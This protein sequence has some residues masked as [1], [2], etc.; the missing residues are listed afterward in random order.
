ME[1][2]GSYGLMRI[3]VFDGIEP[4]QTFSDSEIGADP[5]AFRHKAIFVPRG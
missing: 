4:F 1:I 3:A 5:S 2:A